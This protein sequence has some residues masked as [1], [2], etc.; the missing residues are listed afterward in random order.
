M[1]ETINTVAQVVMALCA[2]GVLL[3]TLWKIPRHIDTKIAI[4]RLVFT[5]SS[6]TSF[7]FCVYF[8]GF[9]NASLGLSGLLALYTLL[10]NAALFM[11]SRG[12]ATR[13]EILSMIL[14]AAFVMSVPGLSAIN[15]ILTIQE[16]TIG[17]LEKMSK[18]P[19]GERPRSIPSPKP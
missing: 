11:T 7:A 1:R 10:V 2:I 5:L 12:A 14:M 13:G 18:E 4:L 15:H 16:R 3:A 17:T 6:A 9:T 8:A 19:Q